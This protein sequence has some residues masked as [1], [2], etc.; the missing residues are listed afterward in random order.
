M[1]LVD[2]MTAHLHFFTQIHKVTKSSTLATTPLLMELSKSTTC[3]IFKHS[4]QLDIII[5]IFYRLA[6]SE[7]SFKPDPSQS[8]TSSL[9]AF[10]EL[11]SVK[12]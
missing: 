7:T 9:M 6:F 3:P 1:R 2:Q 11:A 4:K 5:N 12:S 10:P 8:A